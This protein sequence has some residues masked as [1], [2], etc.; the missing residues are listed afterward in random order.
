MLRRDCG[1]AGPSYSAC[2]FDVTGPRRGLASVA[3]GQIG[4]PKRAI[5]ALSGM[6]LANV[7]S[8]VAVVPPADSC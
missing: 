3:G 8:P 5:P 4:V 1:I 7:A 6:S 2:W